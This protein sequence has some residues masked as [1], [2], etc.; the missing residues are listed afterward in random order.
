MFGFF[1][2]ITS[3]DMK[4]LKNV[5]CITLFESSFNSLFKK[6]I[7]PYSLATMAKV[8]NTW[9]PKFSLLFP[10]CFLV[11][12]SMDNTVGYLANSLLIDK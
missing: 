11:L 10:D 5:T 3:V 7:Q 12:P 6:K 4:V 2:F 8:K 9:F 1:F